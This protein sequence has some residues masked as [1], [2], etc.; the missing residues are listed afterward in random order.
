MCLCTILGCLAA[1][2]IGLAGCH[3][4]QPPQIHYHV[5]VGRISPSRI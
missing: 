2:L 1:W 5:A 4:G 3:P